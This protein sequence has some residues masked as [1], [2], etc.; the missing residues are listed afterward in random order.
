MR[1]LALSSLL[2]GAD[3]GRH[4]N[5]ARHHDRKKRTNDVRRRTH[6]R[7]HAAEREGSPKLAQMITVAYCSY[8]QLK[9]MAQ[10]KEMMLVWRKKCSKID[11]DMTPLLSGIG[12][13]S[14]TEVGV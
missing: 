3:A 9:R 12:I 2:R 5:S 6:D 8:R 4:G 7:L 11:T 13:G 10:R 1:V 14:A